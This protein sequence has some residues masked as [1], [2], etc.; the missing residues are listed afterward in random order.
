[1]K[2]LGALISL[3][4]C[5]APPLLGILLIVSLS[6]VTINQCPRCHKFGVKETLREDLLGIFQKEVQFSRSTYVVP[7]EKYNSYHRCKSCGHE[8]MTTRVEKL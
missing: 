8:W 3:F 1:M 4:S 7:H 5:I 2:Q 6:K